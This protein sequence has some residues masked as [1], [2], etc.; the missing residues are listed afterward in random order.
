MSFTLRDVFTALSTCGDASP[1][2][3]GIPYAMMRHLPEDSLSFLLDIYN[4]MWR[5]GFIP[6]TWKEALIIPIPKPGKDHANPLHYLPIALI[7][8]RLVWF[9]EKKNHLS[10]VQYGFRRTRSTTDALV[11]MESTI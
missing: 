2:P 10:P 3:D 11:R 9:L 7:S 6:P 5:D 1:G 8:S 4:D